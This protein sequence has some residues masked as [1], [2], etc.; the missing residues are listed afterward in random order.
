MLQRATCLITV[1][2]WWFFNPVLGQ[3]DRSHVVT[4]PW[5][6]SSDYRAL[7]FNP[8]FLSFEGW[9]GDTRR[10][11]GGLEGGFSLKSDALDRESV[12]NQLLGREG[13][14]TVVWN[15]EDWTDA[16]VE[17]RLEFS[18]SLLTAAIYRRLGSWGV[19]YVNRR[20]VSGRMT[21]GA[22]AANMF[23]TG[24]LGLFDTVQLGDNGD[25]VSVDQFDPMSGQAWQGVTLHTG[26]ILSSILDGTSVD[27]Q[28]M[29][30]HEI[31]LSRSWKGPASWD[32]HTGLGGRLLLGNSYFSLSASEGKLDAFGAGTREMNGK[33]WINVGG[34]L[35]SGLSINAL[36]AF[37]PAGKGWGLDAGVTIAK[38]NRLW[39]CASVV[40]VGWMQWEGMSYEVN[41]LQLGLDIFNASSDALG[42]DDWMDGAWNAFSADTWFSGGDSMKIRVPHHPLVNVGVAWRPADMLVVTGN[43]SARS[44]QALATT[45][46]TA[47]AAVGLRLSRWLVVEAGLQR[48][49]L[50]VL[51][52]PA[53]VRFQMKRGWQTGLRLSDL[54]GWVRGSQPEVGAQFCFVRYQFQDG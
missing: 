16:L 13:S 9:N 32:V 37:H 27:F 8:S 5:T 4:S 48:Q 40:D 38:G 52:I 6:L 12:W 34:L 53:S 35:A 19:A 2:S 3:M 54:S 49:S 30:S 18:G 36:D 20:G 50:E 46:W 1:F 44:S 45:G 31:G 42:P 22:S 17:E 15:V 41:D 51:R 26:A 11:R 21:L 10:A 28:T 29:R 14:D 33:D 25:I 39:L 7:G 47:S 24:G 23:A 43:V